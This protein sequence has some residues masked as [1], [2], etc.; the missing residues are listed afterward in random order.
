MGAVE[1]VETEAAGEE[2][3]KAPCLG[4]AAAPFGKATEVVVERDGAP[5]AVSSE[6]R[7][8]LG[9]LCF[10]IF[11]NSF[12]LTNPFPYAG[13]MV[14]DF[15]LT[16]NAAEA[17]YYAGWVMT[18]F[19][20]GRFASSFYCGV[21]SDKLGGK[22][23]I[24]IGLSSCVVFQVAFGFAPTFAWALASRLLLGLFNGIAGVAKAMIP[25]LV[26]PED[27]QSAMGIVAG[28]WNAGMIVGP[29]VGGVLARRSLG[30]APLRRAPYALPNVVGAAL[31][32]AAIVVL[33]R[34]LPGA[35]AS[36]RAAY[37]VVPRGD[38]G[39]DE[40]PPAEE[41]EAAPE[42]RRRACGTTSVPRAS[43]IPILLYCLLSIFGI[44]YDECYPLWC[45]A[46]RR[47]G[48]L[49]M[50]APEIGVVLSITAVFSVAFQF[51]V[52][53]RLAAALP[54]SRLFHASLSSSAALMVAPVFIARLPARGR[55]RLSPLAWGVL[56]LQNALQ[57]S[58]TAAAYT[59]N[60]TCINNSCSRGTRGTVNGAAM[61]IASAFKAAGPTAGANLFALSLAHAAPA[62][63]SGGARVFGSVAAAM[64]A[65]GELSRRIMGRAY[66][67][68]P[69]G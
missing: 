2:P 25:E 35:A 47:D 3:S 7:R 52:F 17:G 49:A 61:S 65:T 24:R 69:A 51:L 12:A 38:D 37:E 57:R 29:A 19:M 14:M 44:F 58:S 13:Y 5:E 4:V 28:M 1:L 40:A 64:A 18:A 46:P 48:G 33:Q 42:K 41:E 34:C 15:G 30:L 27:Q 55:G 23:V 11:A 22:F 59:C 56:V 67:A 36:R 8:A 54:P 43:W 21:L 45:M 50:T 10:A 9:A 20:V 6:A 60:F 63:L 39:D 26:R 68:A 32:L 53:P 66:D 16:G 62:G 31:A